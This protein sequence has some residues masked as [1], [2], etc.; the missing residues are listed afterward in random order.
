MDRLT[1]EERSENMRR[2]RARD[3][4]PEVYFRKLLFAKGYRYSLG[5]KKVSGHPDLWMPKYNL[6]V[7]V[8]GCFWHRHEGCPYAYTPKTKVEFWTNKFQS[9]IRRDETVK[10]E[11]AEKGVRRLVV[12]ECTLKA[13][14]KK[15]ADDFT[16]SVISEIEN[17]IRSDKSSKEI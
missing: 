7:F 15:N 9:N 11:L 6:A 4:K 1:P 3:T 12:W 5:S 17:F 2:I 10:R 16:R 8:N 14:Q 13:M